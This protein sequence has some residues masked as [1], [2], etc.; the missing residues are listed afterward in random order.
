MFL[1]IKLSTF[2]YLFTYLVDILSLCTDLYTV[3]FVI[4]LCLLVV[5][6]FF[7]SNCVC[8]YLYA[9]IYLFYLSFGRQKSP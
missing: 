1:L 2:I 8:A 7:Y 5:V 3:V 9:Y 6:F 4:R